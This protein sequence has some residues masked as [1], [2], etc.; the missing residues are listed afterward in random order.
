MFTSLLL[1]GSDSAIAIDISPDL[2]S[3]STMFRMKN[4]KYISKNASK[5]KAR[6]LKMW[7]YVPSSSPPLPDDALRVTIGTIERIN[8]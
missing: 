4:T 1:A 8:A 5:P 6:T 2:L 3:N 7:L